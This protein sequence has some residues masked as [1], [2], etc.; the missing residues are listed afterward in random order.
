MKSDIRKILKEH[1]DFPNLLREIPGSPEKL[2]VRGSLREWPEKAVAIVGTRKASALGLKVAE[3]FA[4]SLAKADLTIVS[5]LAMG[6]DTASHKGALKAGGR[7]IAV[8]GCGVDNV[9]PPQNENLA[10]EIISS[11]GA[12]ISEYEL[13]TP[14]YPN[15]FIERNRIISGLCLATVVIEAPIRS[16]AIA[17]AGFA[18]TQGRAV[19][20]VPGPINHPNYRGS[21][22]LI[23]DGVTLVTSAKEILEELGFA[24]DSAETDNM[25][26]SEIL[27]ALQSAG[28]PLSMDEI[29][30]KTGGN[31]GEIAGELGVLLVSQKVLE[32]PAGYILGK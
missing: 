20:A 7:T 13:G 14:S 22:A 30:E 32:T 1:A 6:I 11:G 25:E 31:I 29:M 16:G 28:R 21:H 27:S 2:F 10:N 5:G 8:L 4:G 23:R 12:I 17:T 9:Y 19:F 15:Q 24:T 18:G 3:E 26:N